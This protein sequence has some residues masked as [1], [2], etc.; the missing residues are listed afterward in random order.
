[1]T[2]DHV[3]QA[4]DWQARLFSE[5]CSDQDRARFDI[6]LRENAAHHRAYDLVSQIWQSGSFAPA[7]RSAPLSRRAVLGAFALCAAGAVAAPRTADAQSVRTGRN[8]TRRLVIGAVTVQMDACSA[9]ICGP[10][11]YKLDFGQGRFA[12]SLRPEQE[13][14]RLGCC[15]WRISGEQGDY[16]LDVTPDRMTLAVIS[17]GL[18]LHHGNAAAARL[19]PG[20]FMV[21]DRRTLQARVTEGR[22]GDLLAWREGRAIFHETPLDQAVAEMARYSDRPVALLSPSLAHLRLSGVFHT[23]DPERFFNALTHLL[24]LRVLVER[25]RIAIVK[26]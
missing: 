25:D 23:H 17:G 10:E 15:A 16:A 12:F 8:Q 2:P 5:N 19:G 24:P 26:L 13:A 21:F 20:Q 14:V 18:R 6:W 3:E 9:L 22:V 7:R 11:R 4:A 1:M